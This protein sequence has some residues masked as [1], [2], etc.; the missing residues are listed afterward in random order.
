MIRT[1]RLCLQ[2][3]FTLIEMLIGL[4]LGGIVLAAVVGSF[5]SQNRSYVAQDYV[6]EAQQNVRT[7]M[8]MMVEEIRMAGYDPEDGA[9]GATIESLSS[10]EIVFTMDLNGNGDHDDDD[11][12]IM[13]GLYTEDG[14]QK[15]GR[16]NTVTAI[17]RAVAENVVGLKFRYFDSAG[18]ETA[19]AANVRSVE[20]TFAVRA[21]TIDPGL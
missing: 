21:S 14:V 2:Q 17:N 18:G 3:G 6:A 9:A 19:I 12:Y 7:G 16:K 8:N 11:E 15:L 1:H 13:Y 5:Q 10:N 20:I 4:L